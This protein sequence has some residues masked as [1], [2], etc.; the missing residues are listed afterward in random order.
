MDRIVSR[1]AD[2]L[3]TIPGVRNVGAHV[4]RALLSDRAVDVNASEVWVNIEP[5]ARYDEPWPRCGAWLTGIRAC[6]AR[7]APICRT[8]QPA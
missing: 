8:R 5:N 3:R 2:E 1:V 4:G 6:A 7:Y